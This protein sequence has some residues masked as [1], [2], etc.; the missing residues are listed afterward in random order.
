MTN[1]RMALR[2][3]AGSA[4]LLRG[5]WRRFGNQ[6]LVDAAPVHVHDLETPAAPLEK[7]ARRRD[8]AELRDD[9]SAERLK[10]RRRLVRQRRVEREECLE[11]A[12]RQRRIDEP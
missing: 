10:F 12:G 3:I 4:R 8:A 7:I 6:H 5:G 9:K 11:V 2:L 1:T